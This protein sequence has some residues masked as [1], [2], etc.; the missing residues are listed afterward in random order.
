M[1]ACPDLPPE[2]A[3]GWAWPSGAFFTP[4]SPVPG[5]G[6]APAAAGPRDPSSVRR[7]PPAA[8]AGKAKPPVGA[9]APRP[10]APTGFHPPP[11]PECH[12]A[13]DLDAA[14]QPRWPTAPPTPTDRGAPRG[15]GGVPLASDT[16]SGAAGRHYA[17]PL[18]HA[19]ASTHAE[20]FGSA[21]AAELYPELEAL[22]GWSW[23]WVGS[24]TSAQLV[25]YYHHPNSAIDLLYIDSDEQAALTR[26][27]P[28]GELHLHQ[29][30]R[31]IE[32]LTPLQTGGVMP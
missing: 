2:P 16:P 10:A 20:E 27:H 17:E 7:E 6:D 22:A 23:W 31:L 21:Q 12:G 19:H 8:R 4:A 13:A 28:S 18:A 25:G 30:G 24:A 11:C 1:S 32:V 5:R 14:G 26:V 9:A 15:S 3:G 29:S